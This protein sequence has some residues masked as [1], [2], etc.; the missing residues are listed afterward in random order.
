MMQGFDRQ[1]ADILPPPIS[2]PSTQVD[3]KCGMAHGLQSPHL[4]MSSSFHLIFDL[5]A[6]RHK[7]YDP[8][9]ESASR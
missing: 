9:R 5:E 7:A 4:G 3:K 6:E 1:A 2:G 8:T